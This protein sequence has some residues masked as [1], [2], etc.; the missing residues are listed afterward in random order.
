MAVGRHPVGPAP[1]HEVPGD[2]LATLLSDVAQ[3]LQHEDDVD[4][5]LQSIVDAA[6]EAVPGAQHASISAV[7]GR[8]EVE[9]RASTD[10]LPRAVDHAQYETRQGPCLDTLY[11]Q[12]TARIP[13]LAE[14]QRWPAFTDRARGLGVGSMLAVQLFVEGEDLGALNILSSEAGA[15][16]EESEHVA[17]LFASHAAIA[18]AGAQEAEQLR[19]AIAFRDLIG[20]AKGILMERYRLTGT[21][22]FQALTQVSQ[23]SNRKLRD[24][25]L[26]LVEE[27]RV[28]RGG[29]RGSR[30]L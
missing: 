10:G 18:M 8:R 6:A 23:S 24:V 7:T 28:S 2:D 22:A 13:D 26:Q 3:S 27:G 15:F 5:M 1:E 4:D 29:G 11:E 12:R 20:Q 14:E 9:T 30:T 19:A 21:Q 17:L 25:A 16:D